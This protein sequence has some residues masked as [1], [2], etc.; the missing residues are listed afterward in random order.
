MKKPFSLSKMIC[1]NLLLPIEA[2]LLRNY[3]RIIDLKSV[4]AAW[5]T[6][7]PPI[8]QFIIFCPLLID[9]V[10][11]QL[12]LL[13]QIIW[14]WICCWDIYSRFFMKVIVLSVLFSFLR[15]LW[16]NIANGFGLIFIVLWLLLFWL[17]M[18]LNL[19]VCWLLM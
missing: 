13:S 5:R 6:I 11:N 2:F 17:I 18:R 16:E 8:H 14:P 19:S 1:I 7:L 12:I 3:M 9:F 4:F 10:R 15:F